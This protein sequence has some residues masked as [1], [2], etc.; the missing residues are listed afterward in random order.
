MLV[1]PSA[2]RDQNERHDS[3]FVLTGRLEPAKATAHIERDWRR[4]KVHHPASNEEGV[5]AWSYQSGRFD[6]R[7]D[8]HRWHEYRRDEAR[9]RGC[10]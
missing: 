5:Q 6:R 3:I 8:N 7:L 1:Y 9:R 10:R 4:A 2:K